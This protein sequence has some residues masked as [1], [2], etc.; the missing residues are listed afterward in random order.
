MHDFFKSKISALFLAQNQHDEQCFLKKFRDAFAHSINIIHLNTVDEIINYICS[1]IPDII[2]ISLLSNSEKIIDIIESI[3]RINPEIPIMTVG[4]KEH[5]QN[6]IES[7]RH[8]AQDC[9][10]LEGFEQKKLLRAIH[11]AIERRRLATD[12]SKIRTKQL[13]AIIESVSD[14]VLI[15]SSKKEVLFMNPIAE[16]LLCKSD[17][18][19]VGKPCPVP[20]DITK[21]LE[22]SPTNDDSI[23]LEISTSLLP[24]ED[25]E[26]GYCVTL[27]DVTDHKKLQAKLQKA[28]SLKD[29]FIAHMSHELRTPMNGIIGMTS[30]LAESNLTDYQKEYL[31]VI[32]TSSEN[33]LAMI[34]DLLD[35]SKIEANRLAIDKVTFSLKNLIDEC[36]DIFTK[37]VNDKNIILSSFYSA[38]APE[39]IKSD[40]SRIKQI[41]VNLISNAIRHTDYGYVKVKALHSF[42]HLQ[43]IVEDTGSGI[44]EIY[45]DQL[46]KPF[47]QLSTLPE[48]RQGGTGLGLVICKK[49]ANLLKGNIQLVKSTRNGT[50]FS[51]SLP[52]SC[53]IN[54]P[55][56]KKAKCSKKFIFY[57]KDDTL[58]S[59]VKE[60]FELQNFAIERAISAHQVLKEIGKYSHIMIDDAIS[61]WIDIINSIRNINK[62]IPTTLFTKPNTENNPPLHEVNFSTILK[63]PLKQS[64]ILKILHEHIDGKLISANF[65]EKE[66]FAV[67]TQNYVPK[68]I[69]GTVLIAED[70][71][72]NQ[73]VIAAM[74]THLGLQAKTVSNGYE[75]IEACRTFQ[76]DAILMDCRMPFLD[77]Y[78]A[79]KKIRKLSKYYERIPI[80]A[81]TAETSRNNKTK[82]HENGM[83]GCLIKPV[84][85]DALRKVLT[86]KI[87]DHNSNF[88][89]IESTSN[90]NKVT[91]I[92]ENVLDTLKRVGLKCGSDLLNDVLNIFKKEFPSNV[93]KLKSAIQDENWQ[94]VEN[95]AHKLKGSARNIGGILLAEKCRKIEE[96]CSSA[97]MS[98]ISN[99]LIYEIEKCFDDVSAFLQEYQNQ[100]IKSKVG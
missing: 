86:A 7:I 30:L 59:L 76:Y 2:F 75:A 31:D 88:F 95:I 62:N 82:F 3:R 35:L 20:F 6:A 77:G 43:I 39:Y 81:V 64:D 78:H 56:T 83:D 48:K 34:N 25:E 5:E 24:W 32:K 57:C 85:I 18:N 60:I 42:D 41:I 40:P 15:V 92:D 1:N 69:T 67:A 97:K 61:D 72:T 26:A 96:L 55:N 28:S 33:M 9:I 87:V 58:Y 93:Q 80:I 10:F 98:K 71:I 22:Y 45:Q 54:K 27:H 90:E 14:G 52:S 47:T 46:F 50:Q 65:S 68:L 74:L 49:L 36:L 44:A 12:A 8:G 73:K 66:K 91:L 16:H 21:K 79:A 19:L 94:E 53:K 100:A 70:N 99:R 89:S 4:S 37:Q 84:N 29:E 23:H 63:N 11:Y 51:L 13:K 17:S 38:D